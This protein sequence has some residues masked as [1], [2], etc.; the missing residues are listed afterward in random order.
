[1]NLVLSNAPRELAGGRP[2]RTSERKGGREVNDGDKTGNVRWV[3]AGETLW[4]QVDL[5]SIR[6]VE[7]LHLLPSWEGPTAQRYAVALSLDGEAWTE[8]FDA[9]H[10]DGRDTLA[11]MGHRL[12]PRL[13]QELVSGVNV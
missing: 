2:V 13:F 3:G 11:G 7:S 4:W 12:A 9:R 6:A 5:E 8:L 10:R 1:M